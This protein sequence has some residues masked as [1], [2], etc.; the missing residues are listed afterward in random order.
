VHERQRVQPRLIAIS[1]RLVLDRARTLLRFS[2]LAAL[3]KPGS[4]LFQL[5]DLELSLSERLSF[6]RELVSLA[7]AA[8][9]ALAVNDRLDLAVL[10][11][12]DGVHLGEAG[13]ETEDV[14]N[15]VGAELWVSRACHSVDRAAELEAD[16]VLLAPVIAAR[17]SRTPLGLDALTRARAALDAAGRGTQLFALGGVDAENAAACV[18]AG[19]HGVAVIGAVLRNADDSDGLRA[20]VSALGIA[21]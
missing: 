20:L 5:R 14:R 1:D 18:G 16:A 13:I 7:H 10:L 3:A 4:V 11:D 9:Q 21:R 2:E 19:A 8:G 12:A 17:K 6:G 15:V